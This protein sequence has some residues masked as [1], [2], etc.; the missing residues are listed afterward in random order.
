MILKG[1]REINL[2]SYGSVNGKTI[3]IDGAGVSA[4][5]NDNPWETLHKIRFGHPGSEMP[6]SVESGWST[7]DGA[8]VLG[9]AQT[10]PE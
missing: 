5:A 2:K 9:Y 3:D 8:D 7:Q 4:I 10:L 6:S 1:E